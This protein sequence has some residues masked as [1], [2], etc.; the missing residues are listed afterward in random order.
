ML[1]IRS[2]YSKVL[3]VTLLLGKEGAEVSRLEIV[4]TAFAL[5]KMIPV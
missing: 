3:T 1:C 2:Y 5:D 4:A